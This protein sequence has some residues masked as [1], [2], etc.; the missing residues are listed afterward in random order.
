MNNIESR[1]YDY[2]DNL[3]KSVFQ[4]HLQ[5][6]RYH[7]G[8]IAEK[9]AIDFENKLPLLMRQK[10]YI[11]LR[12]GQ[13]IHA[14]DYDKLENLNHYLVFIKD[15][16]MLEE[17]IDDEIGEN[18]EFSNLDKISQECIISHM[19]SLYEEE[20]KYD[21]L[22]KYFPFLKLLDLDSYHND[23]KDEA[24]GELLKLIKEL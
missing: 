7:I 11:E 13:N 3:Y 12:S 20:L 17:A 15:K 6:Q 21:Y 19:E 14:Q 4:K 10:D 22:C 2:V 23:I 18:V 1:L 9:M 16:N 5:L 8:Q 24:E